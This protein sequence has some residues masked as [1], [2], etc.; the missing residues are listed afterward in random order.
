MKKNKETTDM[1]EKTK[2]IANAVFADM[3]PDGIG[4][5]FVLSIF[6]SIILSC[7]IFKIAEPEAPTAINNNEI[8]F[9]RRLFS[10]GAISIEHKAVKITNEITP[11]FIKR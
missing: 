7:H 6:E 10:E 4:L 8:A 2:P 11:G 1:N 3:L 9:I 5:N